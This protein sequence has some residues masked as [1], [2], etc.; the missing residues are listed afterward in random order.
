VRLLAAGAA[1]HLWPIRKEL[2]AGIASPTA[3]VDAEATDTEAADALASDGTDGLALM[4]RLWTA[5]CKPCRPPGGSKPTGKGAR[6]APRAIATVPEELAAVPAAGLLLAM[7]SPTGLS[8]FWSQS[9]GGAPPLPAEDFADDVAD[10][11]R[12]AAVFSARLLA[13][14]AAC[15]GVEGLP[16]I[17]KI[18]KKRR[19]QWQAGTDV[20]CE[21][22]RIEIATDGII[23]S[24]LTLLVVMKPDSRTNVEAAGVHYHR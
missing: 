22:L 1:I 23:T 5:A 19:R 13:A 11:S 4:L 21:H 14:A 6:T 15:S 16:D 9:A 20:P 18:N 24:V 17:V 8:S 2:A 3:A 7:R 12:L 10:A